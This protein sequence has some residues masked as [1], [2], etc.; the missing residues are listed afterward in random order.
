MRT[1]LVLLCVCTLLMVTVNYGFSQTPQPEEHVTAIQNKIFHR[2]HELTAV[3]GY[4]GDDYFFNIFPVGLSYTYNFD[5]HYSWEV[6][7]A[8]MHFTTEKNLKGKLESDYG[9]TPEHFYEP[10]GLL[11]SHLIIRPFY[12]KSSFLNKSLVNHETYFFLGG[13][14]DIYTKNYS[15]ASPS[16]EIGPAVSFGAGMKYFINEN[17]NVSF[18][19][20]DLITNRDGNVEN[21]VWFGMNFGFRF[22]FSERKSLSNETM[23]ALTGYIK[24]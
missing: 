14:V 1:F 6:A 21:S 16:N 17:F 5:D 22:N 15:Y 12:G 13:G 4:M 8:Y 23:K 24:E 2:Y 3:T 7:R 20:H 10:K 19:V 9:A 18:E 11:L